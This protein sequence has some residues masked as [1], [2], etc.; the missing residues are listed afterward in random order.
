MKAPA[1]TEFHFRSVASEECQQAVVR[2]P[3]GT[4]RIRFT[5]EAI[6]RIEFVPQAPK[7]SR[8]GHDFLPREWLN[9]ISLAADGRPFESPPL[10]P[11]GTDFQIRVWT[12]LQKIPLGETRSYGDIA[13][14]IGMP[15]AARA[16]GAAC[17]ANP[18]PLLIP[19]HRVLASD[20][21]L[22][23]FSGG[24]EMKKALLRN[25]NVVWRDK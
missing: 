6:T 20:G 8:P 15:R 14:S 1:H 11:G 13:K 18:V 24:L 9:A 10:A 22:G 21:T 19:C 2:L 5:P 12:E 7:S 25:E 3:A 16:V 17:G 4:F 23:G